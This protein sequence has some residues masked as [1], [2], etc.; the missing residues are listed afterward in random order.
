MND[1]GDLGFSV[2]AHKFTIEKRPNAS[3]KFRQLRPPVFPAGM[4]IDLQYMVPPILDLCGVGPPQRLVAQWSFENIHAPVYRVPPIVRGVLQTNIA[5]EETQ[6]TVG[7]VPV[8][9]LFDS[10]LF[11]IPQQETKSLL[12]DARN[13]HNVIIFLGP[14]KKN[15]ILVYPV[16]LLA[17]GPIASDEI[18]IGNFVPPN[19]AHPVATRERG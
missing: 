3:A 1:F 17:R 4:P 6:G 7:N 12:L 19:I 16:D 14:Y 5:L 8:V 9:Q 10:F 11:R 18:R 13:G 2:S 15:S